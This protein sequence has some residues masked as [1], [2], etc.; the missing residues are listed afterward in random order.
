MSD[1]LAQ[2]QVLREE[3]QFKLRQMFGVDESNHNGCIDRIVECI[4]GSAVME[5]SHIFNKSFA[6]ATEDG[7]T[8]SS[9]KAE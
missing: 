5:M 4:I 3:A 6:E 7:A 8:D 2:A 1:V 9:E